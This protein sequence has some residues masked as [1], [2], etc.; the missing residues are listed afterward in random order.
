[1]GSFRQKL[2]ESFENV[3]SERT[4]IFKMGFFANFWTYWTYVRPP[5]MDI[6]SFMDT[7]S[8]GISFC[9]IKNHRF[10]F[11]GLFNTEHRSNDGKPAITDSY[12]SLCLAGYAPWSRRG[13][14]ALLKN[15]IPV[16]LSN[17]IVELFER[18]LGWTKFSV[19]FNTDYISISNL[20]FLERMDDAGEDHR[21]WHRQLH[22][23]HLTNISSFSSSTLL[24]TTSSPP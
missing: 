6:I 1:M 7:T 24:S 11:C 22:H 17:G 9:T 10:F 4:V 12:F 15:S 14:E 13:Y 16:I 23:L 2:H 18:Y 20:T 5:G 3:F 19:K 8:L 21:E